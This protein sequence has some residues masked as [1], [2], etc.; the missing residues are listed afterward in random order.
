MPYYIELDLFQG[1]LDLLLILLKE[2]DIPLYAISVAEITASWICLREGEKDIEDLEEFLLLAAEI[3]AL[4]ARLLLH[5]P[6]EG[7][8]E[9]EA[10]GEETTWL[11]LSRKLEEYRPYQEAAHR[12]A[13]LGERAALIFTKPLD[14]SAVTAALARIDPLAGITLLDLHQAI[15]SVLLRFERAKETYPAVRSLYQPRITLLTQQ[16]LILRRLNQVKGKLTFSSFF[17]SHPSRLEVATTFLALL[18]LARRGRVHIYQREAF[19]E[20]E[21]WLKG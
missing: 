6:E 4:K 1:P 11:E 20:I 13:E 3:L 10:Q 15:K 14:P 12:L 7:Q 18:E 8:L 21:V 19:G 5:R 17:T 2:E 9:E 16:R